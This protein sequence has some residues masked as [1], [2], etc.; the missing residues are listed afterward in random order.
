MAIFI[1]VV[2]FYF[3]LWLK[4]SLLTFVIKINACKISIKGLK[5]Y[6]FHRYTQKIMQFTNIYIILHFDNRNILEATHTSHQ[7][8]SND[9]WAYMYTTCVKL[10]VCAKNIHLALLELILNM[11]IR[12]MIGQK[13]EYSHFRKCFKSNMIKLGKKCL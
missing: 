3:K 1:K 12:I 7:W 2:I 11:F 5:L 10:R 8:G 4:S 9:V 13:D 6:N